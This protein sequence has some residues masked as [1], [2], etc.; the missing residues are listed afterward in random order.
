MPAATKHV[1]GLPRLVTCLQSGYGRADFFADL[2]AGVT[3]GVVALPLAMA[4]AIASGVSPQAGIY[5][6]IIAGFLIS[7]LGGSRVQIG[8][9]T[10][11]FIVVVYGIV[12]RYGLANLVICTLGAGAI[13]MA[14]GALR[15]GGLIRFIPVSI[16]IGFTNGI[17]VLI[18]LSQV[19]DFLG[20]GVTLPDE[21]FA[22]LRILMT[23]LPELRLPDVVVGMLSLAVL[24]LWPKSVR[25][26][27]AILEAEAHGSP[28]PLPAP[29]PLPRDRALGHA[30]RRGA[31]LIMRVPGPIVVLVVAALACAWLAVPL[32]TI[33]TRFGG[34]PTG[35]PEFSLPVLSLS[36]MRDLIAPTITIA[37]LGAIESLLSARVADSMIG[38]RHD[39]NQELIAQGVA[40]LVAPLFGGIPA[41]GA[42]A[43]TAT[44]VRT[45]ART[46]IAGMIHALTLLIIVLAAAP[47]AKFIPL[48]ALSAVLIVVAINMGDWKAFAEIRRYSVPY[49]V[50]LLTTFVFT[51]AFDLSTAVEVG[52]VLASLF[53]IY[54]VSDLTRVEPV[55]TDNPA[56]AAYRVFG[57][58]FFGSVAKLEPLL[59]ADAAARVVVLDMH[60]VISL[61]NTALET[62]ESLRHMLH[63]RRATLLLC[64]LNSHPDVQVR[65]SAFGK[66]LG[67]DNVLADFAAAMQRAQALATSTG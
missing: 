43:R 12:S 9:P 38:D 53:F 19:K 1:L 26:T 29:L 34:I 47:L 31:G 17:A 39:P 42:I 15:L 60:Q 51:V 45:G 28:A 63:E 2:G 25:S 41:T 67:A 66:S 58:L 49:R 33:G 7:A 27:G 64:A 10:G 14:L 54:R 65:R 61:D 55:S 62:L 36:S 21:F 3:V 37:L 13:L 52:L 30:V 32:A 50:V 20:L 56:I 35:L 44:N 6:G 57:A 24:L 22:R 40:N 59:E 23:S 11:A 5:T 4:F 8:G 46:P 16:V 18:L 48:A